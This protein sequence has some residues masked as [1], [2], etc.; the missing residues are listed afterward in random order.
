MTSL[1]LMPWG[2]LFRDEECKCSGFFWVWRSW[3][4]L[5]VL[6]GR[7]TSVFPSIQNRTKKAALF[8]S[9]TDVCDGGISCILFLQL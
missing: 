1:G 3:L 4:S 9:S 5:R 7:L 2:A 8:P 6:L